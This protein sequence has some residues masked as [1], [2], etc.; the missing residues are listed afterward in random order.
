MEEAIL[1]EISQRFRALEDAAENPEMW[2]RREEERMD[3]RSCLEK[4]MEACRDDM[5]A[6]ADYVRK[7]RG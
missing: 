5:N 3:A 1:I 6:M 2:S 4:A 7:A